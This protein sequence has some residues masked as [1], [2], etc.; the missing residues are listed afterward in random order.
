MKNYQVQ[1]T[2][3]S[4]PIQ[5]GNKSDHAFFATPIR[6]GNLLPLLPLFYDLL[7]T[8]SSSATAHINSNQVYIQEA[9]M[10]LIQ[11]QSKRKRERCQ[12]KSTPIQAE[13]PIRDLPASTRRKSATRRAAGRRCTA[14]VAAWSFIVLYIYIMQ[15]K[16]TQ[17]YGRI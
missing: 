4:Y 17:Y 8:F 15:A 12:R 7:Y 16:Y 2:I 9:Y 5:H 13:F 11:E 1:F 14:A 10:Q 3:Y 6:T